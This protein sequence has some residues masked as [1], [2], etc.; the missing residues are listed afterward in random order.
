VLGFDLIVTDA[1]DRLRRAGQL[2]WTGGG[3]CISVATAMPR[4]FGT[5]ELR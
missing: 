1:P 5:L 3:G 4:S 2:V